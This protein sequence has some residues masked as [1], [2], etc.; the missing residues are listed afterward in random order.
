MSAERIE[1]DVLAPGL[2]EELG[3]VGGVAGV[4]LGGSR[5]RGEHRATSDYDLGIYYLGELDVGALQGIADSPARR[6]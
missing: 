6:P 3:Q 1:L 2:V 4:V 5:A